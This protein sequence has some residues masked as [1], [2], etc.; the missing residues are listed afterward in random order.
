MKPF[1]TEKKIYIY[2]AT[3]YVD[4]NIIKSHRKC[5]A[6]NPPPFFVYS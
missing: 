6:L 3:A 1:P 5:L 2:Q 4:L